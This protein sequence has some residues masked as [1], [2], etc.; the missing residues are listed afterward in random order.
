VAENPM[1]KEAL[2]E[3]LNQLKQDLAQQGLNLERF[4]VSCNNQNR[5]D[6]SGRWKKQSNGFSNLFGDGP[7]SDETISNAISNSLPQSGLVDTRI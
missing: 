5:Q 7:E 6:A 3:H 4:S 1:V 2:E